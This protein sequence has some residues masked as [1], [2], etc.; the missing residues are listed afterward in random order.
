M[1]ARPILGCEKVVP[2]TV[3]RGAQK[4][5]VIP[6]KAG[7]SAGL[8]SAN[9][10][11]LWKGVPRNRGGVWVSWRIAPRIT[12]RRF[13]RTPSW[14]EGEPGAAKKRRHPGEGRDLVVSTVTMGYRLSSPTKFF[15]FCGARYRGMTIKYV[16]YAPPNKNPHHRG[17]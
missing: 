17:D 10:P 13:R 15:K 14:E 5:A 2:F 6:A 11:F 1:A 9:S 12:P 7:I 3:C 8:Q 4:A 16:R